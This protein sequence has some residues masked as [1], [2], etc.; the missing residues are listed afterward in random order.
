MCDRRSFEYGYICN[1]C[2]D[3][4]VNSG[5]ETN[6]KEFMATDKRSVSTRSAFARFDVEFPI[7]D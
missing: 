7:R 5:P 2:F 4:L 3:E 1:E 6:V